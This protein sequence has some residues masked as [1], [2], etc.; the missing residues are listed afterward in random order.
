MFTS[1]S[2]ASDP[3]RWTWKFFSTSLGGIKATISFLGFFFSFFGHT[4][5]EAFNRE[6][7]ALQGPES[8]SLRKGPGSMGYWEGLS[9]GKTILI[10]L[11]YHHLKR[12]S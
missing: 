4:T 3:G 7:L 1:R 2:M 10:P 12:Q 6:P 9:I 8:R 11:F 5:E